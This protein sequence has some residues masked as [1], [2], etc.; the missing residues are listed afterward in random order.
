MSVWSDLRGLSVIDF[1]NSW[2]FVDIFV[3]LKND[4]V[5]SEVSMISEIE[6][7]LHE[8]LSQAYFLSLC[9]LWKVGARQ[10]FWILDL[11]WGIYYSLRIRYFLY[12]DDD[13]YCR[14]TGAKR[15]HF[16]LWL[17]EYTTLVLIVTLSWLIF[18]LEELNRVRFDHLFLAWS[19]AVDLW[20]HVWLFLVYQSRVLHRWSGFEKSFRT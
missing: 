10:A 1:T 2:I 11:R 9:C 3:I 20:A 14:R 13:V 12:I 7:W 5:C 8:M 16:R 6:L 17:N 18:N 19:A 15:G 4:I